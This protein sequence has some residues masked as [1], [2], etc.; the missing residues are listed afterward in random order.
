[1]SNSA[2]PGPEVERKF[3]LAVYLAVLRQVALP[4]SGGD[5][6]HRWSFVPHL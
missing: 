4:F 1:M 3:S 5:R 2:V 6:L